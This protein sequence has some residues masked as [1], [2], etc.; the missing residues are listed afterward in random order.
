[1]ARQL[2]LK[3]SFHRAYGRLVPA[4]RDRVKKALGLLQD[5]LDTGYAPIGL[6][7]KKLGSEVYEFRVGLALR[8]A[9][10]REFRHGEIEVRLSRLGIPRTRAVPHDDAAGIAGDAQF[11]K[12]ASNGELADELP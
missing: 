2:I 1:M 9:P 11:G 8:G 3:A 6:G 10:L 5:Y 7:L 4:E 12:G